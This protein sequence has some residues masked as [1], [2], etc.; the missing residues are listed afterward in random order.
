MSI[1]KDCVVKYLKRDYKDLVLYTAWT[2][3]IIAVVAVFIFA[4]YAGM[5]AFGVPILAALSEGF[6]AYNVFVAISAIIVLLFTVGIAMG[7]KTQFETKTTDAYTNEKVVTE[8][9]VGTWFYVF[10]AGGLEFSLLWGYFLLGGGI[11]GKFPS[12]IYVTV[13]FIICI[14]IGTPIS[15]AIARCKEP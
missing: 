10:F 8:D 3:V 2:I 5:T 1:K 15:C 14:L 6:T 9:A 4:G 11:A 13:S 7:D 12:P